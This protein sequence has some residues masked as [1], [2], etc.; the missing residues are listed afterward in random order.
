MFQPLIVIYREGNFVYR[1][2]GCTSIYRPLSNPFGSLYFF[3]QML[4]S[5]YLHSNTS[6]SKHY[7]NGK[8]ELQY[9]LAWAQLALYCYI[10]NTLVVFMFL[11]KYSYRQGCL[12]SNLN[13]KMHL[14]YLNLIFLST[15][16]SYVYFSWQKM[17][18]MIYI[19]LILQSA[20]RWG[21]QPQNQPGQYKN[22]NLKTKV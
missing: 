8:N 16:A 1:H 10:F 9:I 2:W 19:R 15:P 18:Q 3:S 13:H 7:R 11:P 17:F 21:I 20:C 4:P 12:F 14:F 22:W 6:V 5:T